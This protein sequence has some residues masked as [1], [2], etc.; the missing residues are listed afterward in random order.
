M[1]VGVSTYLENKILECMRGNTFSVATVYIQMHTGDPG[2]AGTS[3][4]SVRATGRKSVTYSA[5]AG[6]VMATSAGTSNWTNGGGSTETL[7]HYSRWDAASGGNF[8]GS[9]QLQAPWTFP[10]GGNYA[11]TSDTWSV[12]PTAA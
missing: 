1:T 3:N 10:P 9:A 11:L 4:V 6:G 8:L 12:T 2:A 7:T 5:A